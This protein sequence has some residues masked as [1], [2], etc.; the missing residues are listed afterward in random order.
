[1]VGTPA[2]MA[3]EQMSGKPIDARADVFSFCTALWEALTGE[4]P[5]KAVNLFELRR[6]IEA[7]Q[8]NEPARGRRMPNW[9]RREL[10]R[11][12]H[13]DPDERH[14]SMEAL[15]AAIQSGR[16]RTARRRLLLQLGAA[17]ALLVALAALALRKLP[18]RSGGA[19]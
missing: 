6:R 1:I 17:L 18:A 12:L 7:A 15:L 13:A 10:L 8:V 16:D 2:Y 3:P 19:V 9:L 14:P 5:F 4:R 11:G